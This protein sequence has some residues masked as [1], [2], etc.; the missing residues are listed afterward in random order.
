M[1]NQILARGSSSSLS[2]TPFKLIWDLEGTSISD[3]IQY[4][5]SY[6]IDILKEAIDVYGLMG[7]R[8]Q[9]HSTVVEC[10]F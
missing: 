1:S 6:V 4:S 10:N 9:V 8:R 2:E 3:D 5:E 7:A